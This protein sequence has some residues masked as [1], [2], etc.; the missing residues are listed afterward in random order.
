MQ[1][2]VDMSSFELQEALA[3]QILKNLGIS[4]YDRVPSVT[5]IKDKTGAV[6]DTL[7]VFVEL[8]KP[9]PKPIEKGN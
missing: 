7:T 9:L 2:V 1:I 4:R 3:D 5:L 8:K 6:I